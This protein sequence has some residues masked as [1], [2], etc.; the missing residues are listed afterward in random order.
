MP[1]TST[2]PLA[3]PE[4]A[5]APAKGGDAPRPLLRVAQALMIGPLGALVIF[6]SLYFGVIA[7]EET[8]DAV[9]WLVG[10]WAFT[11]G[12]ASVVLATRLASGGARVVRLAMG[13]VALHVAFGVVKLAVYQESA[14]FTFMA[15]DVVLLAIL[16]RVRAPAGR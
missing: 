5:A 16:A 9:D 11:M 6:G 12:V 15:V 2:S 3:F 8:M 10:A 14:A 1:T 13:L 4:T 7:P